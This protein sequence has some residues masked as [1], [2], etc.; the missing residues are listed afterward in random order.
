MYNVLLLHNLLYDILDAQQI[1]LSID[2]EISTNSSLTVYPCTLPNLVTCY[3]ANS[4]YNTSLIWYD[5]YSRTVLSTGVN[6]AVLDTSQLRSTNTGVYVCST[7]V[8]GNTVSVD[9]Q[10]I[11]IQGLFVC[12]YCCVVFISF[13]M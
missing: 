3:I 10:L 5:A 11:I 1:Q 4:S 6:L 13:L 9:L 7:D 8:L 2:G 12:N